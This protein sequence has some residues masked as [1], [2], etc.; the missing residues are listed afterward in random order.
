VT[1][2]LVLLK[3]VS[4][5]RRRTDCCF[6]G[7]RHPRS[8]HRSRT[9]CRRSRRYCAS[10]RRM[11]TGEARQAL[12]ESE[13][14][15]RSIAVVTRSSPGHDRR[16]RLQRHLP[17]WPAWRGHGSADRPVA[18]ATKARQASFRQRW[19]HPCVVI[20]ELFQNAAE[21]AFPHPL[22][23]AAESGGQGAR[24]HPRERR[25]VRSETSYGSLSG[26]TA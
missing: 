14:R 12:E 17:T 6:Q 5:I 15:V 23:E 25:A 11:P 22:D 16:G 26:T 10:I 20:T 18:S 7:R 9:T 4:D 19:P 24:H 2:A 21:H 1:G 3:D 13:R 8:A